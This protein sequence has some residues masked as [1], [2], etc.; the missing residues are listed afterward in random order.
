MK[1]RVALAC[2]R[3]LHDAGQFADS[4]SE[5]VLELF[6]HARDED[7]FRELMARHAGHVWAVCRSELA[8]A[9]LAE[10]VFQTTFLELVRHGHQVR[11][12]G[13]LSAWLDQ[14]ARRAC[15]RVRAKRARQA[16]AEAERGTAAVPEG[17]GVAERRDTAATLRQAVNDLP[18]EY[19][20]PITYRYLQGMSPPEVAR[21]LGLPVAT[22]KTRLNRG[23]KRLQN[24]LSGKLAGVGVGTLAWE[25]VL[26]EAVG[27][28]P[29]RLLQATLRAALQEPII[30]RGAFAAAAG[31]LAD[32]RYL[33]LTGLVI[34]AGVGLG[35]VLVSRKAGDTKTVTPD[36]PP[37]P[38]A[39][40]LTNPF[41][42]GHGA[43]IVAPGETDA[44]QAVA[45]QPDGK[46][47]AIRRGS[48][49]L[50]DRY[51]AHGNW[52]STFTSGVFPGMPDPDIEARRLAGDP[53]PYGKPELRAIELSLSHGLLIQPDEKIVVAATPAVNLGTAEK[54][55]WK[56]TLGLVRVNPDGSFDK[57]FGDGKGWTS[58]GV[59]LPRH[60]ADDVFPPLTPANTNLRTL[61]A[62]P[63]SSG[64]PQRTPIARQGDGKLVVAVSNFPVTGG[65][66]MVLVRFTADGKLDDGPDGYG[67]R[68]RD[69]IAAGYVQSEFRSTNLIDSH[70]LVVQSDGKAVLLCTT[71]YGSGANFGAGSERQVIVARYTAEG[72][73]DREFGGRGHVSLPFVSPWVHAR[74]LAV[75][76]DGKILVLWYS[77]ER[78]DGAGK[79]YVKVFVSRLLASGYK[80]E[81]FG[82]DSNGQVLIAVDRTD[83]SQTWAHT[84]TL[85]K[86]GKILVAGEWLPSA[87]LRQSNRLV[88]ARL[89]PDGR[90]DSSFGTNGY[91]LGPDP[92]AG[93]Q[94]HA[95]GVTPAANGN[96]IIAGELRDQDITNQRPMLMQFVPGR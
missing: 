15:R 12:P 91:L 33:V 47:I 53:T 46:L 11:E 64:Y 83:G 29:L 73:P 80:D 43:Y 2:L 57:S 66:E 92:P 39:T 45:V 23:L 8:D 41:A 95:R 74:G 31:W 61:E 13:A 79:M 77:N 14:T 56:K 62:R 25:T 22:V 76:P 18:E 88:V 63:W 44:Y 78:D 81:G 72:T 94:F 6:V 89:R 86:D 60:A 54:P 69:N 28:I 24:K 70:G 84:M 19:R 32:Y 87:V 38:I 48:P 30:R 34:V 27:M 51:D 7:A 42:A 40:A 10:D 5:Q 36:N 67:Q 50:I 21:A 71:S 65:G 16:E 75:Q 26:P 58:F 96:L 55:Y 20:L 4:S 35:A 93:K 37:A 82:P 49:R 17:A 9:A 68:T 90:P 1:P 3:L 85:Q 59:P 52:D